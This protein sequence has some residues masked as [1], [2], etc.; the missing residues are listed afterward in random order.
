M[1][2]D[3]EQKQ[4]KLNILLTSFFILWYNRFVAGGIPKSG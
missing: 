1:A 3:Y 2:K 4:K